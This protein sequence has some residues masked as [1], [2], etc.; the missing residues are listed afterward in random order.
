MTVLNESESIKTFIES[1]LN[2]TKLPQEVI[3]VDAG[4]T[5]NTVS[6]IKELLPKRILST[7]VIKKGNRSVGRNEAIKRATGEVIVCSDAGCVLD[8]HWLENIT[9]PFTDPDTDVVA[10]FYKP[11]TTSVFEKCLAA[12]TSVM[13]DRVDKNNFLPS[14]RSVAFKKSAWSAVNGYPEELNYC[15][16]LVFAKKMKEQGFKFITQMNALVY[17]P[18]QHSI[19]A[20]AKQFFRYAVGDGQAF[21]IRPQTPL[22]FARYLIALLLLIFFL[23]T[24]N[25]SVVYILITGL[26]LYIVWA[27]RKNYRYVSDMKAVVWL[28]I[29]QFVSDIAVMC[30]MIV[31]VI[32]KFKVHPVII[33]IFILAVVLRFYKIS[34]NFNFSGEVGHNL[35]AVNDAYTRHYI[36]LIGPPTSHPWLYFAPLFYWLY[37]PVLALSQFNPVSYAY[38]GAGVSVL[39]LVVNYFVIRTLFSERTAL[40]SS[41]LMAVSPLFINFSWG[42]RFFSY[43]PLFSLMLL[44]FLYEIVKQKKD[45]FFELGL[46]YGMMFSFHYTPLMLLPFVL[47]AFV[48]YRVKIR[49]KHVLEV[50]SGFVLPVVPLVI[51]D[52]T[53]RTGMIKN[54]VLWIPYRVAGFFGMYPKNTASEKLI[55]ENASSI[56]EFF[57]LS[58]FQSELQV[59]AVLVWILVAICLGYFLLRQKRDINEHVGLILV[60]L[61]L[62][63]GLVA[64]FLHGNPPIHYFV[65]ILFVPVL[66]C[67]LSFDILMKRSVGKVL[68]LITLSAIVLWNCLYYFSPAWLTRA[69]SGSIIPYQS[70]LSAMRYVV[71]DAHGS[72]FEFHRVGPDDTFEGEYAQNYVYL[73][74][75]LGNKP[76]KKSYLRYTVYE[77][78]PNK[79]ILAQPHKVFGKIMIVKSFIAE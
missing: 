55:Q 7:V 43:I 66:L 5:D 53:H 50:V 69:N 4:S 47:S 56:G 39:I 41:L 27:I 64:V 15:E 12:Y 75:W 3:I 23:I 42:A 32:K 70:Q 34:E 54:I 28:P 13:P 58:I 38:A 63:W 18:Q 74:Q 17:W 59:L 78:T 20:A 65:P 24:R 49:L 45:W 46:V 14:S 44:Y 72:A 33:I 76:A 11:K 29:L 60:A 10:G 26:I 61:M 1:L 21:Y 8:S 40:I 68:M 57:R 19:F 30:G 9:Q 73:L 67:A 48:I 35:L 62:V 36:P 2:Q 31:G 52:V 71:H 22:L 6:Q 25:E 79:K 77:T 16:D 51:Y 37:G